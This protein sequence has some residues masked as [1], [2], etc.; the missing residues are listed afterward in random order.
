MILVPGSAGLLPAGADSLRAVLDSVFAA[1]AYRWVE[2]PSHLGFLARWFDALGRWL[3]A[4]KASHPD[5]Y[6]AFLALLVVILVAIFVHAG[7]IFVHTVRARAGAPESGARAAPAPATPEALR[8]AAARFAAE[9]RYV[10]A[11]QA[12]FLALALELDRRK[13]LRFHPSKTPAEL[14]AEARV[15][16]EERRRLG[17][18]VRR[19]YAYAFARIPCGPMEY[20]AWR[21]EIGMEPHAAA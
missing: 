19:L 16:G 15:A 18:L 21:A 8:K 6:L 20:A 13:L 10:E 7:W 12:D 5:G 14:A 1:P 11:M 17:E 4:F 9:G 2:R 3:A